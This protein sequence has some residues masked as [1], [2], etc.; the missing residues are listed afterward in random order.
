M[1][2]MAHLQMD[3]PEPPSFDMNIQTILQTFYLASRARNYIEGQPLPISVR[4]I[5]DVVYAHPVEL[6]RSMLDPIIFAI[7][8]LVMSEHRKQ[9]EIKDVGAGTH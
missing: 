8:D 3:V 1:Q 4:D 6:P 5:T 7:D 2:V 9:S